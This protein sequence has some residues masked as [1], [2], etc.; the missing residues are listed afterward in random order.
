MQAPGSQARPRRRAR[1]AALLPGE[2]R[3]AERRPEQARRL[4]HDAPVRRLLPAR[5]ARLPSGVVTA[6]PQVNLGTSRGPD[7]APVPRRSILS[8][9]G[10]FTASG[11]ARAALC[12]DPGSSSLSSLPAVRAPLR[13]SKGVAIASTPPPRRSPR[14]TTAAT[15]A[16]AR[17]STRPR[18]QGGA[19]CTPTT[20]ARRRPR[21]APVRR[22]QCHGEASGFGAQ[23]SGFVCAGGVTGCF[24]GMTSPSAGLDR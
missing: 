12:V 7:C 20:S 6:N 17:T 15:R 14:T 24:Q 18:G 2:G 5:R 10:S 8:R 16:E 9:C 13:T 3:L 22:A 21:A 19:I 1:R 4:L 11:V 23:A